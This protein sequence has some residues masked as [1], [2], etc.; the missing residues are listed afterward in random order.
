MSFGDFTFPEVQHKLGLTVSEANLF[1]N[2]IATTLRPE[3]QTQLSLG[4]T[5]ALAISTEKARSEFMIAPVLL[6]LRRIVGDRLGLFSGVS[7]NVDPDRGLTG[8]CDFII[9]TSGLQLIL[10]APL[11]AVVESKNDNLL[12]GLGQCISS[13][14]A[15]QIVN[16]R[17]GL[18]DRI[19]YGAVTTGSAWKFLKIS[20]TY[21]TIDRREYSITDVG[22]FLGILLQIISSSGELIS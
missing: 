20:G 11:I 10:A 21:L 19:V 8:T 18:K 2:T 4:A 6:E 15:T 22:L 3:F 14:V 16:D 17:D 7:L 5:V 9:T 12:T 13:M 1:A